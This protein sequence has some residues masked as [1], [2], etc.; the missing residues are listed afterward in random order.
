MDIASHVLRGVDTPA[1][2]D[3]V[4]ALL[5]DIPRSVAH[6]PDVESVRPE[7]DAWV[8]RLRRLGAGPLTFQVVYGARYRFDPATRDVRWDAVP[9]VGNTRVDGR[10]IVEPRPAGARFTMEARFTLS[11]PFPRPLRPAVE[12]VVQR[13]NERLIGAYLANLATT[14]AGGDGRRGAGLRG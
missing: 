13:E 7:G 9:G 4:Y 2:A 10:W 6:F 11:T 14:L 8:W 12:A 3:A 1:D 5:A